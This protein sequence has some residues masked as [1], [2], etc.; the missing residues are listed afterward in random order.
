MNSITKRIDTIIEM[1]KKRLV[2]IQ[3][4]IR[5]IEN[6]KA[7]IVKVSFIGSQLNSDDFNSVAISECISSTAFDNAYLECMK[8]LRRLE[9]RFSRENINISFVGRAGQGKSLTLRNISGLT[10]E[11]PSADGSD[12]TGAKSV[13][14]NTENA[15]NSYADIT[16][17]TEEEMIEIINT[18]LEE[19]F[20]DSLHNIYSLD[21]ADILKNTLNNEK[22][23]ETKSSQIEGVFKYLD[24]MPEIRRNLS[25]QQERIT[26]EKIEEYVAQYRSTDMKP[27]YTYLSVKLAEIHCHFPKEDAGKIV[28]VDTIGMGSQAIGVGESLMS[29]VKNDSDAI[30]YLQRPDPKRAH[31]EK[32]DT[33]VANN[34]VKNI[35]EDCSKLIMFWVLNQVNSGTAYNADVVHLVEEEYHRRER[36]YAALLTVDCSSE[37]EI[38]EKLLTPVLNQ[39]A[40]N[41]NKIDEIYSE[42]ANTLAENLYQ[43]YSEICDKLDNI[44]ANGNAEDFAKHHRTE[45]RTTFRNKVATAIRDELIFEKYG[46]RIT[47]ECIPMR[48]KMEQILQGLFN[49]IPSKEEIVSMLESG[50]RQIEVV[51]ECLDMMR[52]RIIDNFLS[53]DD[54][55]LEETDKMKNDVVHILTDE[56]HGK[57]GKV[58]P[59]SNESPS[60]WLFHFIQKNKDNRY[61][62]LLSEALESLGNFNISVQGFMI[63]EIRIQLKET[64]D[65]I[66]C[67]VP[68]P[69]T[70]LSQKEALTEEIIEYLK[71]YLFK[72][73]N[74]IRMKAETL[75]SVPNK[76]IYAAL[77]DFYDRICFPRAERDEEWEELYYFWAS[78]IWAEDE[79]AY[80]DSYEIIQQWNTT[81]AQ[82]KAL[83]QKENFMLK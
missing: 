59:Y 53:V 43:I 34:I 64:I 27:Y 16:Y 1:R 22:I 17:F 80:N 6:C 41:I 69:K 31:L 20:E 50:G 36:P 2:S 44:G 54:V 78:V 24:H 48:E 40:D 60:E 55:L 12:C 23:S 49:T 73:R 5:N 83:D 7:S 46:N 61:F 30:I 32:Y 70:P 45:I 3:N 21:E 14:I 52:I 81:L 39:I 35:R 58:L 25:R 71:E 62:S 57:L 74:A 79:K 28:L 19:I 33:D 15:V 4:L 65:P 66:F 26:G 29:T 77:A 56:E 51:V 75:Y 82:M 18:Y 67:S 10:T 72:I 63:H 13:I 9:K 68:E 76:A 47:E 42:Y 8:E 11:I 38:Q 37:D